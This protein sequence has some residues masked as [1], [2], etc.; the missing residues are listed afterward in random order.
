MKSQSLKIEQVHKVLERANRANESMRDE[1]LQL[2]GEAAGA[3]LPDE[4]KWDKTA[5][6]KEGS[7]LDETI[8]GM[9]S[10]KRQSR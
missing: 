6:S 9:Q 5:S 3:A 2:K 10:R 1:L 7:P 4:G 8:S